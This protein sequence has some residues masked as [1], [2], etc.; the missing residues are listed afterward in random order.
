MIYLKGVPSEYIEEREERASEFAR[1]MKR[2][3]YSVILDWW[4]SDKNSAK[5]NGG[6]ASPTS[7]LSSGYERSYDLDDFFAASLRRSYEEFDEKYGKD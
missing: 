1:K 7:S 2:S 3:T 4:E 6:R 5:W